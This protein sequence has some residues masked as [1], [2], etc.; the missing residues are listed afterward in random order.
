MKRISLIV[1]GEKCLKE[2]LGIKE[3]KIRRTVESCLDYTEEAAIE[4]KEKR[5]QLLD[6]LGKAADEKEK[7]V[8]I[9]NQYCELVDMEEEAKKKNSQIKML[10]KELEE[11]VT[12]E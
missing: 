8:S 2:L 11:E 5:Q 3:K 10:K 7:L 12:E 9:I 6:E 4:Y 1:K